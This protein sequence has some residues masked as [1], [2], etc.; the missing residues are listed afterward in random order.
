MSEAKQKQFIIP[1]VISVHGCELDLIKIEMLDDAGHAY[2]ETR[3]PKIDTVA[4]CSISFKDG[5]GFMQRLA[6][7]GGSILEDKKQ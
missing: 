1:P 2:Y 3:Y 6:T 5:P 7:A 4:E